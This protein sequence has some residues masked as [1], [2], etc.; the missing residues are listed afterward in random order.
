VEDIDLDQIRSLIRYLA[1]PGDTPDLTDGVPKP[2]FL[3]VSE[4]SFED[5]SWLTHAV[6]LQLWLNLNAPLNS[7]ATPQQV[8][9][10]LFEDFSFAAGSA[11]FSVGPNGVI[12]LTEL[13]AQ[14]LEDR[15]AQAARLRDGY[16]A[17]IEDGRSRSEATEE[18]REA[19]EEW[20]ELSDEPALKQPRNID[21]KVGTW[22][23][24]E[25]ADRAGDGEL[26]L[27]PPYQRDVVWSNSSSQKLID[28]ILRGIPL[29]SIILATV[30]A[31]QRY[32]IVDG[33]QRLTAIL[34]F[35]G[36]HPE[37]VMF[38]QTAKSPELFRTDMG[39]FVRKNSLTA[40]DLRKH[41]LP[42][43]TLKYKSDDPLFSL[44]G[45]YY[46][47]IKDIK[48]RI[49]GADIAIKRI[50]E[51]TSDY[52]IPVLEYRNT[53]V[54]DIHW[55]FRIY[56]QQGVKL[57]SEEIRNAVFNHLDITKLML[58]ISGDRPDVALVPFMEDPTN[59][60]DSVREIIES[61]GF[62][63][64]RFKRTKVLL[65]V[66]S[67]VLF[68]SHGK[69]NDGYRTPSTATHI[70]A[71]LR[72]IDDSNT[73]LKG[74]SKSLRQLAKDMAEA[75]ELHHKADDAWHPG[76]RSKGK[77][78]KW[79]EL[80]MVAS[81]CACFVLVVVGK[82]DLLCNAAVQ[83]RDLTRKKPGPRS[84]QNRTQWAHISDVTISI[85]CALGIDLDLADN[86]LVA[87]YQSSAIKGLIAL[88][89]LQDFNPKH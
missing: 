34:R 11:A 81:L 43:K 41:Y 36:K 23:I 40:N 8:T 19:W 5:N 27:N 62:G 66:L 32:Q 21:A 38:A 15:L 14:H 52:M 25:F 64:V 77:A 42:F 61:R 65:W 71:F 46:S 57:N 4:I 7:D 16:E 72:Y 84:T 33:K 89:E 83:I 29:P 49:A 39:A 17:A 73:P 6:D 48:V 22:K 56:N 31:D 37:G 80:P 69:K 55:V 24:F 18:W 58:F 47:E 86:D 79:E 26:N 74:S 9:T 54:R 1:K 60:F 78:T 76:F 53:P 44:S 63:V 51:S 59:R 45:K 68:P 12:R 13:G 50:F 35:M 20:R 30:A 87:R 70:D 67:T 3:D 85:L 75:V 88:Q 28:S 82:A 2:S 10:A